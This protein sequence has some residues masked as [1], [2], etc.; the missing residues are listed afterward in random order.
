[1]LQPTGID[2]KPTKKLG[3]GKGTMAGS[4]KIYEINQLSED[5]WR[6]FRIIGEF[7]LGF[8]RL[9]HI[10]A[11]GVAVY[12]SARTPVTA[13][14]YA[15]AERLGEIL[16]QAG[17]AVITGGGPGIM[18]AANKGA[19]EA[20]GTS[21]GLN[22][23]LPQEQKPNRYQTVSL[24]FEFFYARKVMLAKHSVAFVV[25]PGG[26]G[27]LDE[28]MEI[29][30][31]V[32]TQKMRELPIYLVDK[33]YWRGLVTWMNETLVKVGTIAQDDL[34]LFKLVDDIELIPAEIKQYHQDQPSA[35][36]FKKPTAG[37]RMKSEGL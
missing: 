31:L 14:Y 24:S 28:M 19:F 34:N 1:M 12:G 11:R 6:M 30:T 25:F 33:E 4:N 23:Q 10:S 27:T 22:I 26:F 15:Q 35:S 32:Q 17:F 2:R 20:G 36:G 16:A 29:L 3:S 18:E 7:A 37:D 9:N 21:V 13:R 8:D 5:S